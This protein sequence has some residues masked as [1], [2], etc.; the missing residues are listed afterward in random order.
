[1]TEN[2]K[3]DAAS[4]NMGHGRNS[5]RKPTTTGGLPIVMCVRPYAL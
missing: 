2:S 3:S 4:N 1:M 5:N